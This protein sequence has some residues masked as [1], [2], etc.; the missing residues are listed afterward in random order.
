MTEPTDVLKD[1]DKSKQ[2]SNLLDQSIKKIKNSF[3]NSSLAQAKV[4]YDMEFL[5][6]DI[7]MDESN[8]KVE[9]L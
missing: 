5:Q 3:V 4:H 1:H 8:L 9:D 2:E 6:D 7:N